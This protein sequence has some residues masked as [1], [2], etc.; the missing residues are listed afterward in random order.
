MCCENRYVCREE[1]V[2]YVISEEEE[3]LA[4]AHQKGQSGWA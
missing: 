4:A 2:K 1:A 3:E